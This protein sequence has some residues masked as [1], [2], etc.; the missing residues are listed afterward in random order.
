M[1]RN[2]RE[3][4]ESQ[5]TKDERIT[6]FRL[7]SFVFRLWTIVVSIPLV[8]LITDLELGGSP[9]VLRERARALRD[10]GEFAPT[11][12]S[13]AG[14][15][16]VGEMIERDGIRVIALGAKRALDL[17]RILPRWIDVLKEIQPDVVQSI[18]VHANAVAALG[19]KFAPPAAYIQ[20][21]H[22]VQSRPRWH[23]W[24]QGRLTRRCDA[25]IA[26][27]Q[28]V[29][30]KL[31][32]YG[33]VANGS[34]I[35]NGIDVPLFRDA[36]AIPGEERPWPPGAFVIGYVGR[37]DPV[38]NLDVLLGSIRLLREDRSPPRCG[39]ATQDVTAR[40]VH[41]ALVGYGEEE[42]K[43]RKMTES[44]GIGAFVHFCGPTTTPQRW[45]KAFDVMCLPS[46]SE[47]FGMTVVEA[48]AA[49]VPVVA[50]DTPAIKDIVGANGWLFSA[51]DSAALVV[52]IKE[53]MNNNYEAVRRAGWGELA[54][55]ARFSL[56]AIVA[57]H[58]AILKKILRK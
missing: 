19:R 57:Q 43:L 6:F 29:L 32:G 26:P 17:P 36:Q 20:E 21:L 14:K 56:P 49:G 13:L 27:S 39:V 40:E 10:L 15:G 45:Y 12:V 50:A 25:L 7:S 47:G 9:L 2:G 5:K 23:W 55:K 3:K 34:V 35:P 4:D 42:K 54:V 48:M 31:A 8:Y 1:K 41:L 16:P 28:A 58:S 53:V 22:T 38:K 33:S 37:L 30:D 46:I 44:M 51:P 18:L 11:V 24:L 52:A